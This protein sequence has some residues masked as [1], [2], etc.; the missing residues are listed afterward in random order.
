[1]LTDARDY[2]ISTSDDTAGAAC[3]QAVEKFIQRQV[4]VVPALQQALVADPDCGFA[5]AAM[6]LMLHG[7]RQSSLAPA[8]QQ[9]LVSAKK[10]RATMTQ[11]EQLYVDALECGSAGELHG[12]IDHYEQILNRYPTD[13]FALTLCQGELFWLGEMQRSERLSSMV[14]SAWRDDIPGYADYL[15]I[16]AFDLEECGHYGEAE[17]CG[18]EAIDNRR[19]NAWAAHAVAHV[20][21]MQGRCT[22]GVEW[23]SGLQNEW[24]QTNQMK[25]HIWW[26]HCLFHL[27]GKQ[28]DAVLEGYDNWI[29]N[30]DEPLVQAMPDLYIDLQNGASMLWR[31]EH[32]GVAVGDRWQEM[33]A[34]VEPRLHDMSSPFTSA[35]YAVILAAV[36]NYD[37][38]EQLLEAMR[39]FGQCGTPT[40]ADRYQVA[41]VPAAQ[42]AVAH[43]RGQYREVLEILLPARHDLWQMGASHAQREL[44]FQMLVDAAAR[45][46]KTELVQSLLQ[47][48][49]VIGFAEPARRVAYEHAA[50]VI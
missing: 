2:P 11:R 9:S 4:D 6:G 28:H 5:H 16:R 43:R 29:R 41:A 22:E 34:L 42:A 45:L 37:A 35:H 15:S 50:T 44:F 1:M 3:L 12:M 25:F 26:H 23:L 19:S 40:L 39:A 27:E 46:Q 32:A 33:A 31:L 13:A 20:L 18:R 47:E 36:G 14:S 49:E 24:A 48:I 30:R 10:Q 8:L 21:W 7:A 17:A 38:C